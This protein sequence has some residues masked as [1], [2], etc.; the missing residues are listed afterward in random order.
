MKD[1]CQGVGARVFRLQPAAFAGAGGAAQVLQA[2]APGFALGTPAAHRE[3]EEPLSIEIQFIG[4]ART[5]T[6][7]RHLVRTQHATVLL[8]C[9]L[10]QGRRQESRRR[11]TELGLDPSE[12]DAVVLS[13]AHIDHSGALPMLCKEGFG[14]PIYATPG[15]ARSVR[16]HAATTRR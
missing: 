10:F 5:V 9:G 7:S 15:D 8:D 14:G 12:V 3:F 4:A 16:G 6:G 13:H 11:N 2:A 1:A